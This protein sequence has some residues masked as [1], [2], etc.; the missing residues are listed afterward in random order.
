MTI[1]Q[2][3]LLTTQAT[4]IGIHVSGHQNTAFTLWPKQNLTDDIYLHLNALYSKKGRWVDGLPTS[5]KKKKIK[6]KLHE[7]SSSEFYPTHARGKDGCYFQGV[8]P[9]PKTEDLNTCMGGVMGAK[10][11]YA[12]VWESGLFKMKC[13]GKNCGRNLE[14]DSR[15]SKYKIVM[16]KCF[17]DSLQ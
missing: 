16:R 14:E 3:S 8:V 1:Q 15:K 7:T 2:S 12:W 11:Q 4:H 17:A 5:T 10:Q 6:K 9:K 13:R